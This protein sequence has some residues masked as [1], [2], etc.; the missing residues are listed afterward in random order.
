[1]FDNAK[2]PIEK[3]KGK[4]QV[5][6][7]QTRDKRDKI[8]KQET[9]QKGQERQDTSTPDKR[10]DKREETRREDRQEILVKK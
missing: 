9:R 5:T 2:L 1:M 4:R 8:G 10:S 7:G 6:N 3:G